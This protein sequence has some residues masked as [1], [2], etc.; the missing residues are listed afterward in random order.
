MPLKRPCKKT[1]EMSLL[2]LSATR[3]K[4]RGERGHPYLSPLSSLKKGEM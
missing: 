1:F 4:S 3:R 2:K